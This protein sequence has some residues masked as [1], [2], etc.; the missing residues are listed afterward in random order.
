MRSGELAPK[1]G[2]GILEADE[3]SICPEPRFGRRG[4]EIDLIDYQNANG[5][6]A[7]SSRLRARWPAKTRMSS[8]R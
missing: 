3:T 4:G 5:S 8:F 1:R 7:T 2:G 6:S